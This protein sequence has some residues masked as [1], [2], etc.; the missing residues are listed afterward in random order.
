MWTLSLAG[1]KIEVPKYVIPR[2]LMQDTVRWIRG[3]FSFAFN[4]DKNIE[5][6]QNMSTDNWLFSK[7]QFV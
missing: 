5:E 1:L 6:P 2:V 3:V 7:F 4:D